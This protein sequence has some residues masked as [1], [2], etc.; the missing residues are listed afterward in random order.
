MSMPWGMAVSVV[1]MVWA[2]LAAWVSTCLSAAT[3]VA[4]AARTGE[5]GP[6]H[7]A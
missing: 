5:I 6:L 2:L 7:I 1:D 3:A 4:R